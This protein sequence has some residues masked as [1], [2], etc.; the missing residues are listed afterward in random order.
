MLPSLALLGVLGLGIIQQSITY[1][2]FRKS[3]KRRGIFFQV[4]IPTLAL[5][6]R[7]LNAS[8]LLLS[9]VNSFLL[10]LFFKVDFHCRRFGSSALPH[11]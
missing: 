2:R 3:T 9:T 4:F 6:A 7:L 1:R 5:K 8:E 11:I 10:F